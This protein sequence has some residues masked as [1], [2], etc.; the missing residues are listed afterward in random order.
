MLDEGRI[1]PQQ[2][3][4][5]WMARPIKPHRENQRARII[6][7]TITVLAVGYP[8]DAVLEDT[9]IVGHTRDRVEAR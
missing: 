4:G 7:D 3:V 2:L 6:V 1:A 8:M 9:H 5:L